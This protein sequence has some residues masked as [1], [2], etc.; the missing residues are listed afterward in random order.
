MMT[1]VNRFWDLL[2]TKEAAEHRNISISEVARKTGIARKTLQA[3]AAGKITRYDAP[4]IE[5]LCKYFACSVGELI[6]HEPGQ[7]QT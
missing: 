5:A 6:V 3:W 2:H 7:D 4:V 1:L